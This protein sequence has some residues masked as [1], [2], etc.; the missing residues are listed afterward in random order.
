MVLA[1]VGAARHDDGDVGSGDCGLRLSLAL[2]LA[3]EQ[4]EET[5]S[6]Q[7]RQARWICVK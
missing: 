4:Y 7:Q 2:A 1:T 6:Q 3:L 5:D